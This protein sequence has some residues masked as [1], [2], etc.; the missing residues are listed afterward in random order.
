MLAPVAETGRNR[1][2]TQISVPTGTSAFDALG[3]T[4]VQRGST[5]GGEKKERSILSVAVATS[6]SGKR[7]ST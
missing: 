1:F 6:P 4:Q 2:G 7:S 3:R 5:S